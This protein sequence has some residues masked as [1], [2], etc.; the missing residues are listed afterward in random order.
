MIVMMVMMAMVVITAA[1]MTTMAII[2]SMSSKVAHEVVTL[3][4]SVEKTRVQYGETV[5]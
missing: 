5:P 3:V 2:T 4:Q 1:V